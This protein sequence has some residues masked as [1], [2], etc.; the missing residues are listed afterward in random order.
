[1]QY[2]ELLQKRILVTGATGFLGKHLVRT[3]ENIGCNEVI[4]LDSEAELHINGNDITMYE[5]EVVFHLAGYNGGIAFNKENQY[6]IFA[7]NT[8]MAMNVIDGCKRACVQ[9]LVSVVT[10]CAYPSIDY[11]LMEDTESKMFDSASGIYEEDQFIDCMGPHESVAGHGFAKRNLQLATKFAAKQ[12]GLDAVCVCPSTLYGPGDSM[13]PKRTKIMGGMINRFVKA[14][15]ERAPS[16]TCWGT[17]SPFREFLYVKDAADLIIGSA[18]KYENPN[19]PLNLG[20]FETTVSSVANL[21][22]KVVGYEGEINWTNDKT[23]D[24]QWRKF[25]VTETRNKL[26]PKMEF[27]SLEDG[28]RATVD[29]YNKC[30]TAD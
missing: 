22:A 17:G 23:Q 12:Y 26:F 7:R 10:S 6:D 27:T 5:P 30:G 13:D 25:L 15:Q 24:G 29:W 4:E 21:V 9:K 8:L 18:I 20:G 14:K 16:V 3:L 2:S 28:I 1:M 11:A 19:Q